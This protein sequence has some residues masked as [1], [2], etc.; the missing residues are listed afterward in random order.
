MWE[1][2]LAVMEGT[3]SAVM[4]GG[5]YGLIKFLNTEEGVSGEKRKTIRRAG[6]R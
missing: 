3:S 5:G 4:M 2:T 1:K 6:Q